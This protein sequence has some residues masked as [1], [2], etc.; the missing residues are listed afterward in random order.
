MLT[1]HDVKYVKLVFL[2]GTTPEGKPIFKSQIYRNTNPVKATIDNV[3]QFSQAMA[4]L[5]AWPLD[6]VILNTSQDIYNVI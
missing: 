3:Y 2:S 6:Q 1:T 4:A 5:S